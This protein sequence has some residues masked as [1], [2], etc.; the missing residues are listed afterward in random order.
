MSD[1]AI[2]WLGITLEALGFGLMWL[3]FDRWNRD[4]VGALGV[5]FFFVALPA[6]L[7][8]LLLRHLEINFK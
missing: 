3:G 7:I 5:P 1:V 2:I 6:C 8:W 4:D